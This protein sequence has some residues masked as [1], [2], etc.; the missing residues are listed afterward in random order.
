MTNKNEQ[1][2]ETIP[3][4]MYLCS[5]NTS[6]VEYKN[7]LDRLRTRFSVGINYVTDG[8]V[9]KFCAERVSTQ[10]PAASGCFH[11]DTFVACL[12]STDGFSPKF[13]NTY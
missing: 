6:L 1:L 5:Y 9:S 11:S 2:S 4:N 8:V 3:N 13:L 12:P 10:Y 7:I